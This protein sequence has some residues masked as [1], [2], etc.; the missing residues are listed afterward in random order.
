MCWIL[1]AAFF[2]AHVL[3]SN[4]RSDTNVMTSCGQSCGQPEELISCGQCDGKQILTLIVGQLFECK[5]PFAV[6]PDKVNKSITLNKSKLI[7]YL[8]K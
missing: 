5:L 8:N 2:T 7:C 1:A 3:F 6:N 4:C